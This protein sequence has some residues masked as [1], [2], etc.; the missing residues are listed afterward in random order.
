M[1][2][3]PVVLPA[4]GLTVKFADDEHPPASCTVTV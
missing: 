1:L 2:L 4:A 3:V